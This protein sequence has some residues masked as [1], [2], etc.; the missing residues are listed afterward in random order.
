MAKSVFQIIKFADILPNPYRDLKGNPLREEQAARAAH[1]HQTHGL[2][3]K[4]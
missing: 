4:G 1:L 2:L 3:G